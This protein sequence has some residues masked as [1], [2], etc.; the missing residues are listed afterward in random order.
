[1]RNKFWTLKNFIEEENIN[2]KMVTFEVD[3]NSHDTAVWVKDALT[4]TLLQV[5]FPGELPENA[6]AGSEV[7]IKGKTFVDVTTILPSAEKVAENPEDI[8][9]IE[10]TEL[11]RDIHYGDGYDGYKFVFSRP[12]KAKEFIEFCYKEGYDLD[13][14]EGAAWYE[15]HAHIFP[16][17]HS[18]PGP[19]W[20]ENTTNEV[21]TYLWV[22][23]YTD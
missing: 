15:D 11:H 2:G 13:K 16:G 17:K 22:R 12:I 19:A 5:M 23:A 6:F 10:R 4:G 21:W 9:L 8:R 18:Y 20:F 3:E 7:T 14:L 1:M